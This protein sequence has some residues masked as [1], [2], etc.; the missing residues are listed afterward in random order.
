M[1]AKH[2]KELED[3]KE[4]MQLASRRK[5]DELLEEIKALHDKAQSE[6]KKATEAQNRLYEAQID[7]LRGQLAELENKPKCIIC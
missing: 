7:S 4:Q 3:L 6:Q 2:A 1:R 5:N